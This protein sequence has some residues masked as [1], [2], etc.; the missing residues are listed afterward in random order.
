MRAATSAATGRAPSALGIPLPV[1]RP[2]T[3]TLATQ[4]RQRAQL[5]RR[6]VQ[7]SAR[8]SSAGTPR[9]SGTPGIV[10]RVLAAL[11]YILPYFG[12]HTSHPYVL[13][14]IWGWAPRVHAQCVHG[15]FLTP[16]L[17]V[18]TRLR[19]SRSVPA[20]AVAYGRYLFHLYP[21]AKAAVVPFLPA[22]SLCKSAW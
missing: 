8:Y 7:V 22:M 2:F 14:V 3:A 4:H 13:H 9:W 20:D 12:T 17:H 16:V 10:D 5:S 1:V 11:P 6:A 21:A 15:R 19:R 18:P